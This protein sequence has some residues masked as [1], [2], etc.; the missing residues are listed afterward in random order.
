MGDHGGNGAGMAPDAP[1]DPLRELMV[2]RVERADG[3]YLLYFRWPAADS[4]ELRQDATR[5]EGSQEDDV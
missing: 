5:T 1:G 3:R 4:P 2:D